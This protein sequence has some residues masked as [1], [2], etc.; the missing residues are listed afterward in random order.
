MAPDATPPSVAVL[1]S[2][3]AKPVE[4]LILLRGVGEPSKP[5]EAMLIDAAD[6]D[7]VPMSCWTIR[8]WRVTKGG[9][10]LV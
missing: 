9:A 2:K 3:I 8:E 4:D 6:V 10:G 5:T 7:D 1:S